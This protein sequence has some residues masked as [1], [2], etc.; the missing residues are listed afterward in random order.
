MVCILSRC[1]LHPS[2]LA[3]RGAA[4]HHPPR[5]STKRGPRSTDPSSATARNCTGPHAPHILL[6]AVVVWLAWD[7]TARSGRPCKK[8]HIKLKH[9]PPLKP[10]PVWLTY[11][12]HPTTGHHHQAS[13][14]DAQAFPPP[15]AFPLLLERSREASIGHATRTHHESAHSTGPKT[16]KAKF[17]N[18]HSSIS[19]SSSSRE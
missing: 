3:G 11:T 14:I 10:P 8:R 2:L 5:P 19:S 18:Q 6:Y 7:R 1:Q 4:G 12:N 16:I 15:L 13:A 9:D 17:S